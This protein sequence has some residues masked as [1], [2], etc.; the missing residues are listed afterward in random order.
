MSTGGAARPMKIALVAEHFGVSHAGPAGTSERIT[1]EL[2]ARGHSV[3]VFAGYTEDRPYRERLAVHWCGPKRAALRFLRLARW[4]REQISRGGFDSSLSLT[5]LAPAAILAPRGGTIAESHER[6]IAA[7]SSRHLRISTSPREQVRRY[8]ERRTMRDPMVCRIVAHSRLVE[9]QFFRHYGI[10]PDRVVLREGG[11]DFPA[12]DPSAERQWRSAIR[13]RFHIPEDAT[14]FLLLS[15]TPTHDG[16]AD[17]LKAMSRLNRENGKAVL[18][19]AGSLPYAL[20]RGAAELGV[21]GSVRMIGPCPEPRPLFAAADVVVFP[22]PSHPASACV[23]LALSAGLP[24][25]AS[26]FDGASAWVGKPGL[27]GRV[28]KDPGDP[29]ALADAM[30]AMA[31]V[32]RGDPDDPARQAMREE[33]SLVKYVDGIERELRDAAPAKP[34]A[35]P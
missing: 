15:E 19:I 7:Q 27:P 20:Q 6:I 21:R 3:T 26:P 29:A 31:R 12:I 35:I 22:T 23:L 18:I 32:P 11:F 2:L 13:G 4:S 17:M 8:L 10:P 16:G 34:R 30:L 33:L 5:T 28:V 1:A 9:S 14:T 24:V 25:V